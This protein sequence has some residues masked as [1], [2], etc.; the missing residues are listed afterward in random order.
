LVPSKKAAPSVERKRFGRN[1]A[2]L[3]SISGL[4]QEKLAELVGLSARHV[5]AIEAGDYWPTLPTLRK[6]RMALKTTWEELCDQ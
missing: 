3:R 4:S 6:L 2:K 5:Q 1:V